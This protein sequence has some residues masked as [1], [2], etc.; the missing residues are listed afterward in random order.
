MGESDQVCRGDLDLKA[1]DTG[2][3]V[4]LFKLIGRVVQEDR[5]GLFETDG[6]AP[7]AD[8]ARRRQ[9]ILHGDQVALLIPR[10]TSR[11]LQV[12]LP[13]ARNDTDEM[14]CSVA[15]QNQGLEDTGDILAQLL[16]DMS[17][18]QIRLIDLVG[19]QLVADFGTIQEACRIGLFDFLGHFGV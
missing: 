18:C 8:V 17:G 11:G 16:G 4:D 13:I 10:D 2:T 1:A 12:D 15:L 3:D 5:K 7:A 9:E 14:T 19:D 6:G